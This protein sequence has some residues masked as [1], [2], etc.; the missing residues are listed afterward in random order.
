MNQHRQSVPHVGGRNGRAHQTGADNSH[1]ADLPQAG[2]PMVYLA[3]LRWLADRPR[4]ALDGDVRQ[5]RRTR[6]ERSPE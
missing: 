4:Q 3:I 2:R 6:Q 5:V 1:A